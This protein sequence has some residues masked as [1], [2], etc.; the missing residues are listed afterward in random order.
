M[1]IPDDLSELLPLLSVSDRMIESASGQPDHLRPDGDTALVQGFN[2]DL[3]AFANLA[4]DVLAPDAAVIEHQFAC[5]RGAKPQFVFLLAHLKTRGIALDQ[6]CR[7]ATISGGWIGVGEHQKE[8]G[9]RR[10]GDPQLAAREQK[11]I[12]VRYC[13]GG[14]RKGI[15]TG[16]G[17]RERVGRHGVRRQPGQIALFLFLVR[18]AQDGVVHDGVLNVHD[19]ARRWVHRRQLFYRQHALEKASG[20][21]AK[22]FRNLYA[23]QTEF[24]KLGNYFFAERPLF[25]H[26][27]NVRRDLLAGEAPHRR[28][29]QLFLFA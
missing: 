27:A 26:L 19:D 18:P 28:P 13:Q 2:G 6:E 22:L 21:P 14:E 10:V 23:H 24:E 1:K 4:H 17:F 5:G 8:A 11:R 3:V 29:E 16:A 7:D 15:G 20:L 25:V 12:S 9:F